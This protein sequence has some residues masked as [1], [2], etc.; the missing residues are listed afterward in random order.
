MSSQKK[1]PE[2]KKHRKTSA[3]LTS[4]KLALLIAKGAE[5]KKSDH[6]EIID[7]RK[8]SSICNYFVICTASSRPQID[9][10]ADG[11]DEIL[12]KNDI[13]APSWQGKAE[14]GWK[15]LDLINIVVHVLGKEE[16]S[17]LKLEDLWGKSG[18]IY[19]V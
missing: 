9:A 8:N 7:V 11:I 5:D 6:I 18:I 4:Q 10:I 1:R 14:S 16:H 3:G 19:H 17:R 2:T 13:T 12:F 15:I